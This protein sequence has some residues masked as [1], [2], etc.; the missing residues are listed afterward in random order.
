MAAD[1]LIGLYGAVAPELTEGVAAEATHAVLNEGALRLEDYWVRRSGRAW[2]DDDGGLA[3]L[4][5]AARAMAPLL[6]WDETRMTAEIDGCRA[7]RA[8]DLAEVTDDGR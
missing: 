6:G 2:F 4:E 5:P 7:R 8:A 3:A 1:R